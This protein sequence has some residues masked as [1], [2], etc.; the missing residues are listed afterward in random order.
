MRKDADKRRGI[1]MAGSGPFR[2]RAVKRMANAGAILRRASFLPS[3]PRP[4]STQNNG[5]FS[6]DEGELLATTTV[7][8]CSV[9]LQFRRATLALLSVCTYDMYKRNADDWLARLRKR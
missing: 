2:E 6:R 4:S 7:H 9:F 5:Y 3:F 8:A 1:R